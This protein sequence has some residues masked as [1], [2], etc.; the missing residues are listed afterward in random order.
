MIDKDNICL[1]VIMPVFNEKDNILNIIKDIKK[2]PINKEII[3]VDDGSSDGTV[4][5]LSTL[6]DKEIKVYHHPI[7]IGKGAAIRL[8]LFYARGDIIIIQDADLEYNPQDYLALV[9]PIISGEADVVYGKRQFESAKAKHLRYYW[10]G[11]LITNLAN[12]LY[13]INISDEPTC[14]KVFRADI[15][16]QL[17]LHCIGF[18]FCPEVTAKIA[19]KGIKIFE[20]PI[21]YNPRSMKDGKKI[22][23]LDGLKAIYVLFKYKF[24]D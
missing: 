23:W 22:R 1:S 15:L 2:V 10:G 19:K 17:K 18:E 12:F 11:Q 8:G 5:I 9:K 16:K 3:I 14:Y 24:T 6:N 21:S 4:E 7:N 20:V 13:G